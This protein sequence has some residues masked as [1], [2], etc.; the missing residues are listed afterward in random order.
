MVAAYSVLL[1][2]IGLIL[3]FYRKGEYFLSYIVIWF[4]FAPVLVA[5]ISTLTIDDYWEINSWINKLFLLLVIVNLPNFMRKSKVNVK[6]GIFFLLWVVYVLMLSIYRGTFHTDFVKSG[7]GTFIP[8]LMAFY[9]LIYR[10]INP[11]YS[12]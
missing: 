10:R 9:I 8:I 2:L 4:L 7:I 1:F 12:K 5:F 6:I 3:F 11:I